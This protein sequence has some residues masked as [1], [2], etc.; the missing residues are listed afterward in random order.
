MESLESAHARGAT[1]WGEVSGF[2]SSTVQT[3]QGIAGRRTAIRNAIRQSLSMAKMKPEEIGHIHAHGLATHSSDAEESG[4][5]LDLFSDRAGQVP[6]TAAKSYF[7]NL[8]AAGGVVEL[9]ASLLAIDRGR[10]FRTLNYETPDPECS[11]KVVADGNIPAGDS[12]LNLS[13]T[14]QGQASAVLVRKDRG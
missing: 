12:F 11:V 13:V 7:G 5:I 4:A 8:G 1:I 2:G 6:V 9:V 14:P 10:L 3:P